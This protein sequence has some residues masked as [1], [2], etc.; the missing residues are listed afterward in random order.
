VFSLQELVY[1]V[2]AVHINVSMRLL[3]RLCFGG[4]EQTPTERASSLS[5]AGEDRGVHDLRQ[6]ICECHQDVRS[7]STTELSKQY[8][9]YV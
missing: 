2:N 6:L 3:G 1:A 9:T 8:V 4:A 5:H 7:H